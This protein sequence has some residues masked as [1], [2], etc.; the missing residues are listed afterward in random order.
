VAF[1]PDFLAFPAALFI[2]GF[3]S[4]A[5]LRYEFDVS[6][7]MDVFV[8]A[9][10]LVWIYAMGLY[11]MESLRPADVRFPLLVACLLT[12]LFAIALSFL[13]GQ[14]E[15]D[16]S[17]R[18]AV[19]PLAFS[20]VFINRL[21]ISQ[22]AGLDPVML[23]LEKEKRQVPL[24]GFELW[25][26][27]SHHL[28]PTRNQLSRGLKRA[29]D[30]GICAVL[31]VFTLPVSLVAML[32]ILIEDGQPVFYRQQ[33]VGKDGRVFNL[34]KFRSMR[35]S[36]EA[37]GVARWAREN[38][39][40]VTRVGRFLRRSRIDEF[41]QFVNVLLGDMS[42]VGPRPERPE[43]VRHL[44]KS[45][46]NYACR[47]LVKP[48]ITGWAQ[49]NYAYGASVADSIEK[50]KLDFYYLKHGSVI[51]DIIILLQTA[52]VMIMGEGSR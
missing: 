32:A 16:G 26:P 37:D 10:A 22:F 46:P 50:T 33:R 30:I 1:I 35:C 31:L 39:D 44:E 24:E 49:I 48:G 42:L 7:R 15:A 4:N 5:G 34:Y 13:F 52:R 18:L 14:G 9:G 41:P 51:L 43:M 40:R 23:R 19:L 38:D 20:I 3:L 47:H 2:F 27:D 45:I 25:L 17:D 21:I 6:G 29:M 12:I 36:A 11:R 28:R 8:V